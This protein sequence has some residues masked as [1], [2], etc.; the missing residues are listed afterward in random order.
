MSGSGFS[1]H[2]PPYF[3]IGQI[4]YSLHC[5]SFIKT[6]TLFSTW[7]IFTSSISIVTNC[8]I[9]ITWVSLIPLFGFIN[10]SNQ[11]LFVISFN[12]FDF[13]SEDCIV[14]HNLVE[15]KLSIVTIFTN[16]LYSAAG[17]WGHYFEFIGVRL[18]QITNIGGF[19]RIANIQ[20]LFDFTNIH[21]R[22]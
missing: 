5:L 19:F 20:G 1:C 16:I 4:N 15:N 14:R 12:N 13:E 6:I 2:T 3:F 17:T 18:F 22:F 21:L 8:I 10:N 11:N 7:W 9:G